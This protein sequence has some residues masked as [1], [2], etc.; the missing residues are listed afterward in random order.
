[1]SDS[2]TK[3]ILCHI[4]VETA[5]LKNAGKFF[6]DFSVDQSMRMRIMKKLQFLVAQNL[7]FISNI[8]L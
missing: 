4:N 3:K 7:V 1:M 5:A 2:F 8:D 6:C